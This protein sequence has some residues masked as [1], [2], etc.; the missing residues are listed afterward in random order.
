MTETEQAPAGTCPVA[1]S[2][3]TDHLLF[4]DGYFADPYPLYDRL[5]E[6]GPA[7]KVTA[8][9]GSGVW[10]VTRYADVRQGLAD[11][12][13]A[14]HPRHNRDG[15]AG[16]P[17]PDELRVM[18]A[19]TDPPHHTRLR[20]LINAAFTR[21]RI[22]SLRS[23][24]ERVVDQLLDRIAEGD[25]R[26]DLVASLAA[27][28][29]ITIICDL[30]GIPEEERGIFRSYTDAIV[31]TDREG[32]AQGC[33]DMVA[34]LKRIIT[35]KREQPDDALIT[36][37]IEARDQDDRLTESEMVGMG[38]MILIGGYDTTLSMIS[39]GALALLRD[40]DRLA[41]LR[42]KPE[43]MTG[44]V[45]ELLRFEAPVQNAIRRF[46]TEDLE[47]GGVAIPAGSAVVLSIGSAGRDPRQYACP[48]RLDFDRP[49]TTHV[50]FGFGPHF[51]PGAQLGR[52]E[53]AVALAKLITR[54]PDLALA[55]GR[56]T[57]RYRPGF[58][59]RELSTLPVTF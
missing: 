17:L 32:S 9:D 27:P 26:A 36:G 6:Q 22:E 53:V 7:H 45:E 30:L 25:G 12:R 1:H 43:R 28:L 37:L 54:F 48:E 20:S 57:L 44:A 14:R 29:P 24:V 4:D 40:P 34:F 38:F 52:M 31:G 46:A 50:S 16:I 47:I 10:L 21:R 2:T 58:T 23:R 35:L 19:T 51:C 55:G 3:T 56:D 11:Q 13:L 49:D 39:S 8:P 18:L 15:Y 33:R 59:F 42:E 5:R 41:A